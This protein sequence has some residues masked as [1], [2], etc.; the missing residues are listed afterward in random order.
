MALWARTASATSSASWGPRREHMP[1]ARHELA[2]MAPD[3][4]ERTEAIEL[5]L[6]QE[7]RMIE[8]L[9]DAQQPYGAEGHE[10]RSQNTRG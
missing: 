1:V 6:E 10:M 9:R 5:R 8:R 4:R 7:I 3:V 2:V